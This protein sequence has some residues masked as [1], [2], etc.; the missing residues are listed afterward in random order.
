MQRSCCNRIHLHN[1]KCDV[2][3][4]S[5]INKRKCCLLGYLQRND[6]DGGGAKK[7]LRHVSAIVTTA[8]RSSALILNAADT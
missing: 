5:H 7:N 1:A 8:R 2:N 6:G 3:V 4:N